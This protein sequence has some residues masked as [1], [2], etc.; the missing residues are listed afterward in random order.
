MIW[1]DV[2]VFVLAIVVHEF[3][4]YCGFLFVGSKPRFYWSSGAILSQPVSL[5][6]LRLIDMFLVAL[7]GVAAGFFVLFLFAD[8]F[9]FMAYAVTCSLDVAVMVQIH[10]LIKTFGKTAPVGNFR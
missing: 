6:G 10:E 7:W 4:H 2:L 1:F 8:T 9:M 5:N 3:G